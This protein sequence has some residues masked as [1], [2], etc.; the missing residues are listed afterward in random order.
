[1]YLRCS[2]HLESSPHLT[3]VGMNLETHQLKDQAHP[4]LSVPWRKDH[5]R[6]VQ[7]VSP[8]LRFVQ[9]A[10]FPRASDAGA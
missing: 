10:S 4:G 1:M 7:H 6:T 5:M 9:V 3:Q 2:L 8:L